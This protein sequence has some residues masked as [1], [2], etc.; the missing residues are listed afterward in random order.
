MA[1]YHKPNLDTPKVEQVNAYKHGTAPAVAK[2]GVGAKNIA[3]IR[4]ATDARR[5]NSE[6]WS[7]ALAVV[8]N[9]QERPVLF[10]L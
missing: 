8:I 2:F 3:E 9:D 4:E 10:R 5:A 7:H 1:N 6:V